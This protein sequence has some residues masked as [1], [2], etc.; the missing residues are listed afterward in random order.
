MELVYL[1]ELLEFWLRVQHGNEPDMLRFQDSVRKVA[2]LTQD[3]KHMTIL[4]DVLVSEVSVCVAF[5]FALL[6]KFDSDVQ[7]QCKTTANFAKFCD[8][9]CDIP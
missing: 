5:A 6:M 9:I 2:V 1:Q 7:S 3:L 8:A 4:L